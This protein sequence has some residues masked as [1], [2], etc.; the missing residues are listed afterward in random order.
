M[1]ILQVR[2]PAVYISTK[3]HPYEQGIFSPSFTLHFVKY[4][5]CFNHFIFFFQSTETHGLKILDSI[6]V[7]TI[8]DKLVIFNYETFI[9]CNK[10]KFSV[11]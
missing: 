7:C 11:N 3:D 10:H 4:K 9:N 8:T 2:R 6:H 1:S 5:F